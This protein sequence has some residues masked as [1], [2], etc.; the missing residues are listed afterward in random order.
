[1]Y[2]KLLVLALI[3]VLGLLFGVYLMGFNIVNPRFGTVNNKP[4]KIL[5]AETPDEVLD[6]LK[7]SGL[8]CTPADRSD[9]EV[10]SITKLEGDVAKGTMSGGWWFAVKEAGSWRLV[11]SG[12]GIPLCGEVDKYNFSKDFYGNCIKENGE[13]RF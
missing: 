13:L 3:L 5:Q 4:A 8:N 9:R 6:M 7:N 11:L 1:M 12:N 2:R 10:C